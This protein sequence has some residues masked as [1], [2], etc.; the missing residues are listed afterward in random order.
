MTTGLTVILT[1]EH[2]D[3]DALAAMLATWKL[4]PQAV[5]ILPGQLNRNVREF[6]TL[7][8]IHI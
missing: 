1:H 6:L 5:P 7:S 8:L 3:F 2:A 4:N